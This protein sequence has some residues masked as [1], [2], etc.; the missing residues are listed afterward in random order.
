MASLCHPLW[1]SHVKFKLLPKDSEKCGAIAV[2]LS[3]SSCQRRNV[4]GATFDINEAVLELTRHAFAA[5]LKN[6]LD[7]LQLYGHYFTE[8]LA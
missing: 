7:S 4:H 3:R 2:P 5:L 8:H 6:C 1:A